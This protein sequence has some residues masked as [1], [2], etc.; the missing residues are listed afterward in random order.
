MA[1]CSST[2]P[3]DDEIEVPVSVW[4][5]SWWQSA[6]E[7]STNALEFMKRDLVEFGQVLQQ[8]ASS[9]LSSTT[10]VLKEKLQVDNEESVAG[11][12]RKGL[13]TLV[14]SVSGAFYPVKETDENEVLIIK[15]SQPIVLDHWQAELH[16][17]KTEQSTFC[18]E[19]NGPPELYEAWLESFS[20]DEQNNE[21]TD[22]M[23][24]YPETRQIYT[25]LVPL[26]IS[27][28]EFWQRY[29]YRVH[30]LKLSEMR[31][32]EIVGRAENNFE[33]L[34]WEDED[35][36]QDG[37]KET[38]PIT[39]KEPKHITQETPQTEVLTKVENL[40]CDEPETVNPVT[41]A[42]PILTTNPTT[43]MKCDKS[44]AKKSN[45]T[46]N[47][48]HSDEESLPGSGITKL[49]FVQNGSTES[50][51][52][53]GT[54]GDE[55][56]KDFETEIKEIVKEDIQLGTTDEPVPEEDWEQWE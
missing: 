9:A 48:N 54:T 6:K 26:A 35:E 31:R 30:Q 18:H 44:E 49:D 21:I 11:K 3:K 19:P 22:I 37:K 55:W 41:E 50:S 2:E 47:N 53:E 17:I 29:F 25:K 43:I 39:V 51:D 12:A 14:H 20:L 36:G 16:K 4:F 7:K 23:C 8:D 46:E 10:A 45:S 15:N 33:E 5:N 42:N 40:S 13:N 52:K 32:A 34:K 56:E 27:N 1:T 28:L 24:N 38:K